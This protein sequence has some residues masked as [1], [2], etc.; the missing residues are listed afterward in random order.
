M[1]LHR[2]EARIAGRRRCGSGRSVP[3]WGGGLADVAFEPVERVSRFLDDARAQGGAP[4][5]LQ[6]FLDDN[7]ILRQVLGELGDLLADDSAK[8]A[9]DRER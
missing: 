4:H 8:A 5:G 2:N 3:G 7:L 1:H 9:Q 6:F